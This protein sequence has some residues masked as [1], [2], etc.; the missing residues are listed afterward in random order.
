[1]RIPTDFWVASELKALDT[2][3]GTTPAVRPNSDKF[4]YDRANR[5]SISYLITTGRSFPSG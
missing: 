3:Y 5:F 2:L 1:M 4:G